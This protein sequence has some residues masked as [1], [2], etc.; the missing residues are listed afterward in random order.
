VSERILRNTGA[1]AEVTFEADGQPLNADAGVTVT[2]TRADG[3]TLVGG[4]AATPVP[5]QI[6]RY[7]YP[8]APRSEL[9][10][11]TISWT[12]VFAGLTQ[13]LVTDL[14]IVG[15]FYVSLGEIRAR[16][17]LSDPA[18]FTVAQLVEARTWFE[19]TVE[20]YCDVAFVPRYAR[21]VLDGSGTD[22][23]WLTHH[24]LRRLLSVKIDG[25]V[26]TTTAWTPY[27]DGRIVRDTGVFPVGRRNVE[28]AYEHGYDRPPS[29]LAKAAFVAI[30]DK[31]LTDRVGER[32]YAVVTEAGIQRLST[33]GRDRPFGI[34]FVDAVVTAHSERIP[35]IA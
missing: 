4:D 29:P 26:Q 32:Q 12:G 6:G 33:P 14:E 24:Q 7:R 23:L 28:V 2:I 31:L 13:T 22:T 18:K 1:N 11:L 30:R 34:P 17:D 21:E 10:H 19:D 3:S 35:G 25:E 15:G 20:G 8:V 16:A 5:G 27:P 9:D